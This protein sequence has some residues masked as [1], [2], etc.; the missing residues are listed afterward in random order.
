MGSS[1]ASRTR[2][3]QGA[4]AGFVV[5]GL[6]TGRVQTR[7]GLARQVGLG[8]IEPGTTLA[9]S[10]APECPEGVSAVPEGGKRGGIQR[11]ALRQRW[12]KRFSNLAG[13][14][15][16]ANG[17]GPTAHRSNPSLPVRLYCCSARPSWTDL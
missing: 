11:S 6:Q 2:T 10:G 13:D 7:H 9:A 15:G 4:G 5:L 16:Q 8:S 3:G 14:L 12:D 1:D 17:A